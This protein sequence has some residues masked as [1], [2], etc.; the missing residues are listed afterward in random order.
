MKLSFSDYQLHIEKWASS[1]MLLKDFTNILISIR[2]LLELQ[3]ISGPLKAQINVF[4][5]KVFSC[6]N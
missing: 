1:S 4:N 3:N 5:T 2:S 6:K